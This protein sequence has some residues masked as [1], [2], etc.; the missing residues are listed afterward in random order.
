M[1]GGVG[2]ERGLNVNAKE[3][4]LN[5]N[6]KERGLN[7]KFYRFRWGEALRS[8]LPFINWKRVEELLGFKYAHLLMLELKK[9]T[10]GLLIT[11][12]ADY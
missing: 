11:E 2:K 12:L 9:S 6:A 10:K 7:V 5:V 4:G 1:G 3:R 8:S